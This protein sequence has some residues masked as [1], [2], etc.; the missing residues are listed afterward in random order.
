MFFFFFSDSDIKKL[1]ICRG[2]QIIA[3]VYF[4]AGYGP[5][6]YPS[7]SVSKFA[8]FQPVVDF[9]NLLEEMSC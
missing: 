1:G 2:G 3:I 6:D 9:F 5:T 7:E 8:I 4:R